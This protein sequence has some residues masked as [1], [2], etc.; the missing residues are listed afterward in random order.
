MD[1]NITLV[2]RKD[3]NELSVLSIQEKT[4]QAFLQGCQNI[5]LSFNELNKNGAMC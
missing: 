2:D 3:T 4:E 1:K 5:W